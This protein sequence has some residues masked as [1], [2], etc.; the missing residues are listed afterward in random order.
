MPLKFKWVTVVII[1]IIIKLGKQNLLEKQILWA[2]NV[3]CL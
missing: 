3:F 1:N 2:R